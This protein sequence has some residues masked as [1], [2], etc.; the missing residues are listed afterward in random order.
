MSVRIVTVNVY[1]SLNFPIKYFYPPLFEFVS[2]LFPRFYSSDSPLS[3][4][5]KQ[6][7]I[8][9]NNS[10][11]EAEQNLNRLLVSELYFMYFPQKTQ[12]EALPVPTAW[13]GQRS[14]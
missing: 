3:S 1:K 9:E 7:N 2:G 14:E 5:Q 4:S 6:K 10:Q 13:D 11:T 12:A 8:L